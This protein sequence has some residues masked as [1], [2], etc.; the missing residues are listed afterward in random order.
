MVRRARRRYLP[1]DLR[2]GA[3]LVRRG[4]RQGERHV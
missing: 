2:A 4:P 3:A 1:R